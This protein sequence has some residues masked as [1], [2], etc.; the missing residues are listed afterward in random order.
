MN[1]IIVGELGNGNPFIPVVLLSVDEE[2]KE[3]FDFLVDSFGLSI[4]LRVVGRRGCNFDPKELAESSHEVRLGSLIA[5]DFLGKAVEL[6][7]IVP[8]QAGNSQ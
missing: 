6:P 1:P 7:D 8:K 4:S 2:S 3:L 5:D